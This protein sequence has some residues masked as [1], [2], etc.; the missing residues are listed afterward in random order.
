[1]MQPAALG[2]AL[3]LI[4][5]PAWAQT[6]TV[7]AADPHE[8]W[9]HAVF[10]EIYPRS[11]ADSNGDGIGDLNGITS[12]LDYLKDLGVDAIWIAPCFPSPQV[13]FGYDVSDYEQ[14]DPMYGT[15]ADFDRLVAE[16]EEARPARDP[17]LR[18]QPHLR[19]T[20]V[21]PGVEVV[22]HVSQARLVRLAGRQGPGPA[23]QQLGLHVREPGLEARSRDRPVLLPLLL[24]RAARPQL[25]QP[26][27]REGHAGREP[28]LVQARGGRLPAGRGGHALRGPRAPGQPPA[29][30]HGQVRPSQPGRDPRQEAARGPRRAQEATQGGGRVWRRAGGGNLDQRHRGAE[31]VLRRG[32]RGAAAHGLHVHHGEQALGARVPQADRRRGRRGRVARVRDRQPRHRALLAPLRRR[33]EQRRHRQGDGRSLPDPARD[34]DHVLRRGDRDAEQ[35]PARREDVKDPI[36]QLGWPHEKGR[37]G[38]RTPMQWDATENAGFSTARPWLPV[39]ASATTRNVSTESADPASLLNLYRRLNALRRSNPA[40]REGEYVALAGNDPNVL[41]YLRRAKEATVLVALNMSGAVQTLRPD[42]TVH[43]ITVGAGRTLIGTR[44]PAATT[45]P[46]DAIQLEPF[47]VVIADL[48]PS[49]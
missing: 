1:M 44:R 16:G 33:R 27:G 23:A 18:G 19:P 21:V 34:A 12:R 49:R 24:P 48:T 31:E 46:L 47:E 3:A 8:W 30:R 2:A 40:L 26:R 29:A 20:P 13:D 43:R 9:K 42:L 28:L 11:F 4:A 14:I 36:G 5:L 17:R 6:S 41:A 7:P 32:R 38:E 45:L 35:R 25:A 10:Y 37:D 22:A 15:L 39:P